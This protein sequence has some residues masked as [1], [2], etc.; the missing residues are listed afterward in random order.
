[1]I[2]NQHLKFINPF[3]IACIHVLIQCI[4]SIFPAGAHQL[5]CKHTCIEKC[6][7]DFLLMINLHWTIN[8]RHL[9]R[10]GDRTYTSY[11]RHSPSNSVLSMTIHNPFGNDLS[12][13]TSLCHERRTLCCISLGRCCFGLENRVII[14][15]LKNP[16]YPIN[17][18]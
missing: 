8:T 15:I 17:I 2:S 16:C 6:R 11:Y 10:V 1:M 7:P 13:P 3:D 4:F 18:D 9:Y 14:K 12:Q 5:K